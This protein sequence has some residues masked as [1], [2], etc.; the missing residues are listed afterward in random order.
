MNSQ[1]DLALNGHCVVGVRCNPAAANELPSL[2]SEL[3]VRELEEKND[4]AKSR[5]TMI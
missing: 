2:S 1:A 4:A 3:N 5:W